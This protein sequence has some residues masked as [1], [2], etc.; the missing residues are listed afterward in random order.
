MDEQQLRLMRK[1]NRTKGI[2]GLF[3]L[4]AVGYLIYT[5]VELGHLPWA[6]MVVEGPKQTCTETR[7]PKVLTDT[8]V[9][10]LQIDDL[11]FEALK[12]EDKAVIKVK[13]TDEVGG[14]VRVML[15]CRNGDQQG[16]LTKHLIPGE[17]ALF[18]FEDVADCDLDYIIEP[19]LL[20]RTV[21]KSFEYSADVSCE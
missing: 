19:E 10:Q 1:N 6:G 3:L 14:D 9:E 13:N 18:L 5:N 8:V 12:S 20:R 21:E 17:E 16:D 15:Y 11:G 4:I 7:G 2:I